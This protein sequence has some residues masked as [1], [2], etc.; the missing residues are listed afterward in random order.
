MVRSEV[1]SVHN[2]IGNPISHVERLTE[3]DVDELILVDISSRQGIYDIR[4]DDHKLQG[5]SDLMGFIT[6]IAETCGVPLTFGGHIRT[7]EDVYTRILNGADKVAINSA[8]V[9]TPELVTEAAH[10]FGSQ[11]VVV[12]IDYR[13]V[14][15]TP[16]V[17]TN[18]GKTNTEVDVVTWAKKA[19]DL[20]AGE[21]LLNSIDRDGTAQGYDIGTINEVV[22]A[23]EI[24]IIACGGAGH[25]SHF[26]KCFEETDA[27]AVA[28]GNIF[29]FT[30]NAYPRAKKY[31]RQHRSDIR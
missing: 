15:G 4:R 21:I 12:S 9:V 16:I 18:W 5:S 6:M 19:E 10:A 2:I 3:W 24:P 17:F 28:A 25:Q 22:K 29:H 13:L 1:F 7:F 8:I 27:A 30:E 26:K 11:A 14:E 23:V 31:L 20:G